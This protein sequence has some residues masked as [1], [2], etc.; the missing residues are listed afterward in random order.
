MYGGEYDQ[1]SSQ[2]AGGGFLPSPGAQDGASPAAKGGR[3]GQN[4]TLTPLTVCQL[5]QAINSSSDDNVRVDNAELHTLTLVGKVVSV[6][7]S[8]TL[9]Q[10]KVDDGTGVVEV[11]SWLESEEDE[12]SDA[13]PT[14][15]EGMYVRVYGKLQ[16]FQGSRNV[17]GFT[18][19]PITDFNEVTYHLLETTF[20]HLHRTK[21]GKAGTGAGNAPTTPMANNYGMQNSAYQT[22]QPAGAEMRQ[23]GASSMEPVQMELLNLFKAPGP[24]MSDAGLSID[25][26]VQQLNNAFTVDQI[27]TAIEVLVNEGHLYSTID[28]NHFKSTE[29]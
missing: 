6:T 28:D 3:S 24:A 10:Y 9:Q 1:G 22:P 21:G 14:I 23:G 2:F 16:A 18:V 12:M 7:T 19:R 25:M 8:A 27:R 17:V 20:V 29:C 13:S 5:H 26:V 4:D 15:T 11:R